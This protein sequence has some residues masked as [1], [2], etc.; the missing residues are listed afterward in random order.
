MAGTSVT[1]EGGDGWEGSV[2]IAEVSMIEDVFLGLL[3]EGV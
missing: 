3:P 2:G 1:L